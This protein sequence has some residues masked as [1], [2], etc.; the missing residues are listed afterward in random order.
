ML[1]ARLGFC[2]LRCCI[3]CIL[4]FT[5]V[6][7]FVREREQQVFKTSS[8][9]LFRLGEYEQSCH[10]TSCNTFFI[11]WDLTACQRGNYCLIYYS[12]KGY[13]LPWRWK[14]C[15]TKDIFITT[16]QILASFAQSVKQHCRHTERRLRIW[17]RTGG[18]MFC[19]GFTCSPTPRLCWF[20]PGTPY[21]HSLK[22]ASCSRLTD[23]SKVNARVWVYVHCKK[24]NLCFLA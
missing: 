6:T 14:W 11:C 2:W 1:I 7:Q 4:Y 22:H 16:V 9:K 21:I 5:T 13:H 18:G 19:L 12:H 23:V 24:A 10:K 20:S 8:I 15:C 3:L 17:I